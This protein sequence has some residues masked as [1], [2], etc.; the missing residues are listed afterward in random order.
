MASFSRVNVV[1]AFSFVVDDDRTAEACARSNDE[2]VSSWNL[3]SL[4]DDNTVLALFDVDECCSVAISFKVVQ[5]E[6]LLES[7]FLF[8]LFRV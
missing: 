2:F 3:N 6:E 1:I 8:E 5:Q 4:V 7:K